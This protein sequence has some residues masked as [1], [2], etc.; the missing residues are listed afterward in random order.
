M[1]LPAARSGRRKPLIILEFRLILPCAPSARIDPDQRSSLRRRARK[2]FCSTSPSACCASSRATAAPSRRSRISS[3]IPDVYPAG[4][5]DAD[6]EGLVDPDGR[7]RAAG[8]NRESA[9]S[10]RENV[11][12]A[13]RRRAVAGAAR[14]A[15]A[16]RRSRRLRHRARPRATD[17]RASGIVAADAADPDSQGPADVVARTGAHRRTQSAGAPDDRS[18]RAS[19]AA[20]YPV[21]CRSMV[22]RR[23]RTRRLA[24]GGGAGHRAII[25]PRSMTLLRTSARRR[26]ARRRSPSIP[27]VPRLVSAAA[28][29]RPAR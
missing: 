1:K 26:Q 3:S 29:A 10:P 22:G 21:R 11:S 15:R 24:P 7:R 28:R 12:R 2:W 18:G 20:P 25:A 13:G 27:L 19:D 14:R 6:S 17:I 23:A 4:R 8:E 16:W 5:L 9:P